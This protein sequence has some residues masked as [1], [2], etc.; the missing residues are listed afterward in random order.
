MDSSPKYQAI[1]RRLI[2]IRHAKAVEED[3]S[4][5]HARGLSARG[6]SDALALADWL[7]KKQVKPDLVLCSTA[8][9]ARETLAA[10]GHQLPTIL[11]DKLYLAAPGELL[12]QIQ[13][14]DDSVTTLAVVGHNP[15]LHALLH[16]LLKDTTESSAESLMLKFPTS[17]CAVM[18]MDISRWKNVGMAEAALIMARA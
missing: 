7:G 13:Q 6:K 12:A 16:L 4:G 9:R 8:A 18:E 15:G 2:L 3:V 1:Q 14:M 5:D 17:A 11:S 10:L